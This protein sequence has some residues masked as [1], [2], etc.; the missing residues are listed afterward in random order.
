MT[1]SVAS[2]C[3]VCV[4]VNCARQ[5]SEAIRDALAS[6]LAGSDVEVRTQLCFGACWSSPN[7][8][9]YPGGACYANVQMSDIDALVTTI[10]ADS[11]HPRLS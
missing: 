5:G 3:Y 7:V 8:V 2:A 6:K 10:L 11:E 4:N 9:V 1:S